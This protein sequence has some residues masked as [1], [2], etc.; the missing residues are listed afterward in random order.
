MGTKKITVI[1]D[2]KSVV[3][4]NITQNAIIL[5]ANDIK[6]LKGL[7][8]DFAI[9]NLE[10]FK[11]LSTQRLTAR[12]C[13][14]LFYLIGKMQFENRVTIT[15]REIY[16]EM[17]IDQA[18]LSR[19][20]KALE[21]KQVIMRQK[22][23]SKTYELRLNLG[24]MF[25]NQS[26]AYK[27]KANDVKKVKEHKALAVENLP[28]NLQRNLFGDYNILD[29]ETNK[30]L[31]RGNK[32]ISKD[33]PISNKPKENVIISETIEEKDIIAQQRIE[34]AELRE[35]MRKQKE[36]QNETNEILLEWKKHQEE[37]KEIKAM[38]GTK[39]IEVDGIETIKKV[40]TRKVGVGKIRAID[41]NDD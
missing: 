10:F 36:S 3:V 28:Y 35:E 37:L 20:L 21:S 23:A 34:I 8:N 38:G 18:N 26:L 33:F 5:S 40:H 12:Q 6:A 16:E 15:H 7:Y 1:K 14:V 25:V 39:V 24:N 9:M 19:D 29:K 2:G 30:V 17:K 4:N 11:W 41:L 31:V 27:G 22:I 32:E 13:R